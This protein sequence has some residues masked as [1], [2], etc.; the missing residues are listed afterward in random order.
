MVP[1]CGGEGRREREGLIEREKYS[2]P[3]KED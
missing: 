3:R 2:S 1:I